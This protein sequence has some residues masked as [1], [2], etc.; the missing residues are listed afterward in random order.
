MTG[1]YL[2]TNKSPKRQRRSRKHKRTKISQAFERNKYTCS[3]LTDS[4]I[5]NKILT[6][7][8]IS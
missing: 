7:S 3:S 5:M 1:K 6:I 4:A 8:K 2:D